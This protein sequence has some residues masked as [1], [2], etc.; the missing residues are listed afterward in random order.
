LSVI[1]IVGSTEKD[2]KDDLDAAYDIVQGSTN[3]DAI[4]KYNEASKAFSDSDYSKTRKLSAEAITLAGIVVPEDGGPE[5]IIRDAPDYTP[6]I[7]L[8]VLLL[9]AILFISFKNRKEDVEEEEKEEKEKPSKKSSWGWTPKKE[10]A[11]ER[12]A[13]KGGLDS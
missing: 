2:A 11:M 12:K 5:V 13:S 9:V 1:W 10:S 7:I 4:S 3:Q 6:Y 8:V